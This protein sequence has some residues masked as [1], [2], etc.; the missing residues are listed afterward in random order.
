MSD[1]TGPPE[2]AGPEDS[3]NPGAAAAERMEPV[4]RR[5]RRGLRIALVSLASFVLLV[6]AVA[7]GGFLYLNHLVNSVQRIPVQFTKLDSANARRYG[8]EYGGA[9]TVL[10]T[11][12]DLGPTGDRR[13][14]RPTPSGL[15]MLLHVNAEGYNGS[16]VSIP[17]RVMVSVP[18]HGRMELEDTLDIGGP[19]LMVK[20]IQDLTHV[21]INHYAHIDLS[22]VDQAVNAMGGVDVDLP[23]RTDGFGHIFHVGIDDLTGRTALDYARE[24]NLTEEQRV[25]REQALIRAVVRKLVHRHLLSNPVTDFRVLHAFIS[26]LTLDSNF[27]VAEL[28]KVGKEIGDL[29]GSADYV[30]A[31]KHETHG[32]Q[33]LDRKIARQLWAAIRQDAVAAFAK[34]YPFTVTPAAPR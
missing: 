31:P 11:A 3:L 19:T 17:P 18:G 5:K 34:K 30:T 32:R 6:G 4:N 10:I 14:T 28:K 26:M 20:T 23:D 33:Y 12:E 16:V 7:G 21:Q 15:I 22:K 27:T 13:I 2:P 8:S 1:T 9:M 29:T 24:D 25:L